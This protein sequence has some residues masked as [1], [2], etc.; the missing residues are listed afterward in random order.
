MSNIPKYNRYVSFLEQD[1]DSE[2]R[3][4]L[5]VGHMKK[6]TGH[7]VRVSEVQAI[8]RHAEKLEQRV[9]ALEKAGDAMNLAISTFDTQR[10]QRHPQMKLTDREYE[11]VIAWR[12]A[13]KGPTP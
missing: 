2:G 3:L 8:V 4:V 12:A 1:E 6:E 13:K 10:E 7:W 9:A 11:A 5:D